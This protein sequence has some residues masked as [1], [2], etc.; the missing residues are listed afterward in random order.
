VFDINLPT[1]AQRANHQQ[2]QQRTNADPSE[3]HQKTNGE[4]LTNEDN[5]ERKR[6]RKKG[7]APM[8]IS[9]AKD[10]IAAIDQEIGD[11]KSNFNSWVSEDGVITG[12]SELKPEAM[13]RIAELT[14]SKQEAELVL[15][16]V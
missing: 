7:T 6:E 13:A 11:I 2:D 12:S 1:H 10:R 9:E 15:K 4:P 8:F 14:Q 3:N 16:G 5:K